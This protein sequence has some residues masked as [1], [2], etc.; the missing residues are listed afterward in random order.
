MKAMILA[1]GRGARMRPLSDRRPKPLLETGGKPLIVHMLEGLRRAGITD[2]V[3]N[4][5]WLG[6]RIMDAL[7]DGRRFGVA[8]RYSPEP[9]AALD[10]GGG[11]VRALHLL[12]P[13]P[14][15]AVNGDLYTD[16]P[17]SRLPANPAGLAHLVM[18]RNP[19]YH[20][21]GDFWLRGGT[22]LPDVAGAVSG[23]ERLTFAGIGVY[24]PELFELGLVAGG[25]APASGSKGERFGL[26]PLLTAAMNGTNVSG[27]R[28]DGAWFNVGTP[29]QLSELGAFLRA[30][31]P[32]HPARP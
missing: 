23:A 19:N 27:E 21:R 12:G 7:G 14:F 9:V 22:L 15:I 31:L 24:R 28:Y 6:Q 4:H 1:A 25:V 16:F 5:A 11:L 13:E 3:I 17:F 10:T 29:D 8:I 18:V 26:A 32:G 2:V 30:G 20:P